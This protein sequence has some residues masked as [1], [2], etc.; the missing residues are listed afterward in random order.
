[1][2]DDGVGARRNHFLVGSQLDCRRRECVFPIDQED[3]RKTDCDKQI[4]DDA[5]DSGHR[6]SPQAKDQRRHHEQ[7]D[8]AH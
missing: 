1:V 3:E 7:R 4:A 2:S 5:D 8:E 6:R